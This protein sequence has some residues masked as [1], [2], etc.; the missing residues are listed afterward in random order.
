MITGRKRTNYK[1]E[2]FSRITPYDV[3]R[4]YLGEFKVG[5]NI[6]NRMRGDT[7]P[8]L[9]IS[10]KY[11]E[12][13][14]LDFGNFLWR[15]D[16]VNLV[17]QGFDCTYSE[18]LRIID[19]DL[20]LGVF[21][22][23]PVEKS[24]IVTW[25]QP[26]LAEKIPPLI[27]VITRKFTG[28]ELK[29]W[30]KYY[31]G[32]ED[33]RRENIYSPKSIFFNRK[34][35]PKGDMAFCYFYPD[36]EKWKIYRPLAEK[37]KKDTPVE[38]WK[39]MSNVPFTYL[40]GKWDIG[41]CDLLILTKSR[42]DNLVLKKALG[43]SCICNTQAEDPSCL[44]EDTLEFMRLNSN[45]RVICSDNDAKGKQ[46]SWWLTKEHGY[47]HCNVPDIYKE[48]GITDFADMAARHSLEVVKQHFINK[49]IIL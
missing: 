39:W 22:G 46:F 49:K 30:E 5:R 28:E 6:P 23:T 3:F 37:R 21:S 48:E 36:I 29:Y 27:Q 32:I 2:I 38:K 47:R 34:R 14:Y 44:D 45:T 25:Q 16:C 42:K 31:Q 43:I 8:S 15:G 26:A 13:R 40:E 41:D 33:L 24:P 10:N 35:L 18:A 12:L 19:K 20:Q 17:M 9:I 7:N 4:Y 1:E 11:G